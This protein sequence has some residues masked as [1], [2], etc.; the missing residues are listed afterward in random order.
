MIIYYKSECLGFRMS[1]LNTTYL[2]NLSL[3]DVS[4]LIFSSIY[5]FVLWAIITRKLIASCQFVLDWQEDTI[6][7]QI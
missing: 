7:N 4:L 3:R 5:A 2:L 1:L 6:F